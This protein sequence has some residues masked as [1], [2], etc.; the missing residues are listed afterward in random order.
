MIVGAS[1]ARPREHIECSPTPPES[2]Q[3]SAAV[4]ADSIS[5]RAT[6]RYRQTFTKSPLYMMQ[7]TGGFCLFQRPILNLLAIP[8]FLG[9]E[10]PPGQVGKTLVADFGGELQFPCAQ[11]LVLQ[12]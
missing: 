4:G 12:P 5:A 1:I 3:L 7:R 9:V 10:H 2:N 6:L 11:C 8:R